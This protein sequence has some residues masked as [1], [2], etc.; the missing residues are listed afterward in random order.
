MTK[1]NVPTTVGACSCENCFFFPHMYAEGSSF[2]MW[3]VYYCHL[4]GKCGSILIFSSLLKPPAI[5]FSLAM[6]G[7][8]I[9]SCYFVILEFILFFFYQGNFLS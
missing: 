3:E 4:F 1:E 6:T 5:S 2:Y 9:C 7:V 8:Y